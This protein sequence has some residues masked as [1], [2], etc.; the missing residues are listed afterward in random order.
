MLNQS[1]REGETSFIDERESFYSSAEGEGLSRV[2]LSR[3][4]RL[5]SRLSSELSALLTCGKD[6][7]CL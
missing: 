5:N 2:Q 7:K 4:L 6:T 1:G 3:Q